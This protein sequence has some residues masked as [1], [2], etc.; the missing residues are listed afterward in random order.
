MTSRIGDRWET[1]LLWRQEPVKLPKTL[2]VALSRLY[3]I[4][5]KLRRRPDLAKQY[6]AKIAHYWECGY[7]WKLS[8]DELKLPSDKEWYLPHFDSTHPNKPGKIRIVFDAAS[9]SHG[10]SLN[11]YLLTGPDLLVSLPGVLMKFRQRKVAFSGYITEMFHQVSIRNDDCPAQ[12]I[13]WREKDD[14]EPSTY[15]LEVMM[16]GSVCSPYCAQF[17][18]NRNALEF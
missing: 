6:R 18:K 4:E 7:A 14:E 10:V 17:V 13:L 16:F 3:G 9:R 8:D 11:D 2:E 15:Q 5:R 12:R 1:G